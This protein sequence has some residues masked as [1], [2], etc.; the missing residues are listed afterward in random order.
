MVL[1]EKGISKFS[2]YLQRT[3]SRKINNTF[4]LTIN[5]SIISVSKQL[6]DVSFIKNARTLIGDQFCQLSTTRR[7]RGYQSICSLI[8]VLQ[9]I[10][11]PTALIGILLSS[12]RLEHSRISVSPLHVQDVDVKHNLDHQINIDQMLPQPYLPQV[13]ISDLRNCGDYLRIVYFIQ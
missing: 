7:Y 5:A 4:P 3:Y 9:A 8:M 11:K 12:R 2:K 13:S 6:N 10:I 1:S